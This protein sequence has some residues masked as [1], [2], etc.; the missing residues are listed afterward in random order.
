MNIA[1]LGSSYD[2]THSQG[3]AA[4]NPSDH[5][6]ARRITEELPPSHISHDLH[7]DIRGEA[8]SKR[9]RIGSESPRDKKNR[10]TNNRK[11]SKSRSGSFHSSSRSGDSTDS[12]DKDDTGTDAYY[13]MSI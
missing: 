6:E 10:H 8:T 1:V 9:K 5:Y 11:G 7:G 13:D 2:S 4:S 12:D 3:M